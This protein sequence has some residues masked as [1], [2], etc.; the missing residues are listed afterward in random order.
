MWN[1]F[2]YG[3]ARWL[4]RIMVRLSW[5]IIILG[6]ALSNV[7][8][9][10]WIINPFFR[11]PHNELTSIP[12][13]ADLRLPPSVALPI[14]IL[15]RLVDDVEPRFIMSECVCRRHNNVDD[16]PRDIG[17]MALGPATG[18]IHP[19]NGRMADRD[20]ATAHIRR[21]SQNGLVASIAHVWID[22][23]AFGTRFRDLLFI[24]FCDDVNCMYRTYM[25]NRGPNLNKAYEK[26]PGITIEVDGEK[27]DECGECLDA[28]FL[29]CIKIKNGVA[30]AD[31]N[32]AGCARCT[33]VCPTGARTL[34]MEDEEEVYGQLIERI[35][36]I[37]DLPVR[38]S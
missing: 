23:L 24:C 12:I 37:C 25:K 15:E 28:C 6:K 2:R 22:P 19:S 29:G 8:I 11:R 35:N 5:P 26:L 9:L 13:N 34:N 4:V 10:K 16:P 3:P 20:E 38:G 31:G 21:A 33:E 36:R 32:C 17:C 7:P 30:V 1:L 18:R 27:C 14:Q